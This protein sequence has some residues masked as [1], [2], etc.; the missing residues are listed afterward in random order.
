M[1]A[2]ATMPLTFDKLE[3][4]EQRKL[5]KLERTLAG[6]Q[7]RSQQTLLNSKRLSYIQLHALKKA[8]ASHLKNN[9]LARKRNSAHLRRMKEII[10]RYT[11]VVKDDS[12]KVM[13][14]QAKSRYDLHKQQLFPAH[15]ENIEK[16]RLDELE[17]VKQEKIEIELRREASVAVFEKEKEMID[18]I[19]M[20]QQEKKIIE[21]QEACEA[22]ERQ[23]LRV[24]QHLEHNEMIKN[25]DAA[26][27]SMVVEVIEENDT[28]I[29][30]MTGANAD[31]Q[32]DDKNKLEQ[33]NSLN[34]GTKDTQQWP[35]RPFMRKTTPSQSNKL[36]ENSMLLNSR[37]NSTTMQSSTKYEDNEEKIDSGDD[38]STFDDDKPIEI[39]EKLQMW[40]EKEIA[41]RETMKRNDIKQEE[42]EKKVLEELEG[43]E[44]F[45]E[46][47]EAEEAVNADSSSV[48]EN[49]IEY[50][51]DTESSL[52]PKHIEN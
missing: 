48:N 50:V 26:A 32:S 39:S 41:I 37:W 43:N 42:F 13:L 46:G 19:N 12:S 40:K 47:L 8:K 22:I 3:S 36:D 34:H 33:L 30:S 14:R 24:V 2:L 11:S 27:K 1:E 6:L 4:V 10:M 44:K 9:E 52:D 7:E 31:V 21:A 51:T 45:V 20:Q 5:K 23:K 49:D 17:R 16:W 28:M 29:L 18:Q 38:E 35:L 15:C 25:I